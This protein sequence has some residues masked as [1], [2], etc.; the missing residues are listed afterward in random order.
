MTSAL[1]PLIKHTETT[2]QV[3]AADDED[4][5]LTGGDDDEINGL[6]STLRRFCTATEFQ[7]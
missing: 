6:R 4:Q 1:E 2:A 5:H 3:E 7:E